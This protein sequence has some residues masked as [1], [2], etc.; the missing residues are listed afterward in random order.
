MNL[1]S[2]TRQLLSPVPSTSLVSTTLYWINLRNSKRSAFIKRN[3]SRKMTFNLVLE[4]PKLRFNLE[5]S[6][7]WAWKAR[8]TTKKLWKVLESAPLRWNLTSALLS[9][10]TIFH[11]LKSLSLWWRGDNRG[12]LRHLEAKRIRVLL[13]IYRDSAKLNRFREEGTYLI[14]LT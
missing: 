4:L 10:Q 8:V 13:S 1:I 14:S 11:R 12:S 3:F 9:F 7:W 2:M 6:M 5:V